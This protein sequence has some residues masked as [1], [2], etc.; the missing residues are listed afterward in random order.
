MR[1]MWERGKGSTGVVHV[2]ALVAPCWCELVFLAHQDGRQLLGLVLIAPPQNN[3][4][5]LLAT[6][7][8]VDVLLV[9]VK[10]RLKEKL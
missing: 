8:W 1:C 2:Y 10:F 4:G 9:K 3:S 6:C 7:D 5:E